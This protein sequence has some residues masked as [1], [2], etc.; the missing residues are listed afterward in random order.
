MKIIIL[1][2]VALSMLLMGCESSNV[3]ILKAIHF[4]CKN[5]E[6]IEAMI[7][8]NLTKPS[9]E[10][11]VASDGNDYVNITGIMPKLENAM[12]TIQYRVY[13]E[14]K[15][16]K[17]VALE[18]NGSKVNYLFALGYLGTMCKE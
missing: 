18:M 13:P 12:V 9:W 6:N 7:N 2:T 4:K 8:D 5:Y 3:K 14:Q 16:A 10:A 15:T 1:L 11:I 17:F